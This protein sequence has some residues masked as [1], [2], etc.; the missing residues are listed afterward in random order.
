MDPRA[1]IRLDFEEKGL[2]ISYETI[3]L[4]IWSDKQPAGTLFSH[5][6]CKGKAYQPRGNKYAGRC[7]IKYRVSIDERPK[8]VD[9]TVRVG[10]WGINLVIGKGHSGALVTIVEI[11]QNSLRPCASTIKRRKR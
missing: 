11:K 6:R 3:Y 8:I 10:D 2:R 5:L 1:N 4:Y 7:C 9:E